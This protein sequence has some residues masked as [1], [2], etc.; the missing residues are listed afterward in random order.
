MNVR[1]ENR[2][3]ILSCDALDLSVVYATDPRVGRVLRAGVHG[4]PQGVSCSVGL[5]LRRKAWM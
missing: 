5:A 3:Q 2:K 1:D 4:V